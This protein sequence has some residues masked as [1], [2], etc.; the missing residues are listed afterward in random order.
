M[1]SRV[2][3]N[4]GAINGQRVITFAKSVAHD[5]VLPRKYGWMNDPEGL[6]QADQMGLFITPLE[7]FRRWK[8]ARKAWRSRK[9]R[10]LELGL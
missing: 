6:Y 5:R 3:T 4:F 1:S 8:V 2:T 7:A 9:R 10:Q